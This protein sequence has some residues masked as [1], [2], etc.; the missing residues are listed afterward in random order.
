MITV[1]AVPAHTKG[2]QCPT[3]GPL[4]G[5]VAM[6]FTAKN[7]VPA[8]HLRAACPSCN[9]WVK[10]QDPSGPW[11]ISRNPVSAVSR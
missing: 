1:P 10:F 3:H 2:V 8:F 7:V 4:R 11:F 5:V 6:D 9:Q